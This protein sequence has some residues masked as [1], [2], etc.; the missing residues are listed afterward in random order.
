MISDKRQY[1]YYVSHLYAG[2]N[3]DMGILKSEFTP[4]E[5]WFKNHKV[6][7]DLGF[8]EVGKH[9]EFAEL[10]IGQKKPRKSKKNPSP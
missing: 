8:V 5:G 4:G 2:S 7:F 6:L 3:V 1:I 9:Y 10:I